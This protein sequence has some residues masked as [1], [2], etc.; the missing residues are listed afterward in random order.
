MTPNCLCTILL[1]HADVDAISLVGRFSAIDMTSHPAP[2][3]THHMYIRNGRSMFE[4]G[5]IVFFQCPHVTNHNTAGMR[6]KTR[7]VLSNH[8]HANAW[9]GKNECSGE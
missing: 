5:Q 1:R 6:K 4:T 7:L 9:A 8:D 2:G 3:D